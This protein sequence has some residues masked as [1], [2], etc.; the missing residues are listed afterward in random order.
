LSIEDVDHAGG[1]AN[2]GDN[3]ASGI[4]RAIQGRWAVDQ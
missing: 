3:N 4:D 1:V 2:T